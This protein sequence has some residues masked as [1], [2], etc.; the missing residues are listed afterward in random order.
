MVEVIVSEGCPHC[1]R[2]LEIL[3]QSFREE[4][5][6]VI[7]EGTKEFNEHE[8]NNR[9]DGFPFVVIRDASGAAMFAGAGCL[10]ASQI[11]ERIAK[12]SGSPKA[13]NLRRARMD[14]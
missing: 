4:D 8:L 1:D 7:H 3:K 9:V 6:K 13:F 5:Y 12:Y 2:Q 14:S 11:D 10:E